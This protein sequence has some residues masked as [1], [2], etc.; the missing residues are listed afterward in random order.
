MTQYRLLLKGQVMQQPVALSRAAKA[1]PGGLRDR[2]FRALKIGLRALAEGREEAFDGK[3]LGYSPKHH[4]LRDC[5]G[6]KLPVVQE[7]RHNHDLGP[8]HRLIYREFEADDGGLP[9]RQVICFAPRR[10]DRPFE[11][12]A[13]RLGR[14]SGSRLQA[15]D[16]I[17]NTRPQLG[18]RPPGEAAPIRQSLPPDLQ[19]TLAAAADVA[20]APRAVNTP[21]SRIPPAIRRG[22]PPEPGLHL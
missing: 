17:S 15:L 4:D 19:V 3:R 14:E 18:P 16:A 11:V 21:N 10:D 13:A 1:Q 22:N 2:E 12:A 6:I 20:P 8:S 7:S 9:V 5:A